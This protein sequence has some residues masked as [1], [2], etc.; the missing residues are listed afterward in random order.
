MKTRIK[1]TKK[2]QNFNLFFGIAW[3]I[4]GIIKLISDGPMHGIDYAWIGLA[5]LSIGTYFYE[6]KN[7]YLTIENG[8]IFKN[9]PLILFGGL[10]YMNPIIPLTSSLGVQA[11]SKTILTLN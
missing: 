8:H 6:Y 3:V 7:Q 9:Y 11:G 4:L 2:R 1:Y 10:S 5:G